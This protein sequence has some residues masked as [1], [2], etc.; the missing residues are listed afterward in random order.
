MRILI[1]ISHPAHV[2][3]FRN[4]I[5]ILTEKGHTVQVVSREKDI[6]IEL[7]AQYGIPHKTLSTAPKR[8]SLA[9]FA[10][11][12]LVH[13]TGLY[14]TAR[15]FNPDIML[16]IAGTFIAP[17]G[18]LIRCPTVAFYDTEFALLSNT[19]SYPLVSCVCTPDCYEGNIWGNQIKYA[20]YHELAYLHPD[21][22]KP[23]PSVLTENNLAKDEKFFLVRFV[24]W[25]ALHDYQEEGFDLTYK[26][27]LIEMLSHYGKVL[28]SSEAPLPDELRKYQSDVPYDKIHDIMAYASLVVGESAT[29]A[30]EAAVLGVPSIFISTTPR[31]YTNEQENRY[32]LVK[33]FKPKQQ[34]ECLKTGEEIAKI[35]IT[36][37][38]QKYQSRQSKLLKEKVNTTQWMVNF[39]TS[40]F[41]TPNKRLP[42]FVKP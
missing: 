20:G 5:R 2:H 31:G 14:K 11:E 15:Q 25:A 9:G 27:A 29:M 22:F 38:R 23:N 8:K 34:A 39:I 13:C 30:S 17:V 24:G 4:A 40:N 19:V 42:N 36:L 32:G 6:T 16:Q 18:R 10:R 33:N 37:L 7:L 3:F 21:F 12:M 41:S 28:I 1:D 35:P 26:K